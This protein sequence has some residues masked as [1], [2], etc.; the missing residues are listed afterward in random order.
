MRRLRLVAL[1]LLLAIGL[2]LVTLA[3]GGGG[4]GAD[5]ADPTAT[6]APAASPTSAPATPT[7]AASPA[8]TAP[9]G[10]SGGIGTAVAS[11]TSAASPSA[12][13]T[14]TRPRTVMTTPKPI[15]SR[16]PQPTF[17]FSFATPTA[18]EGGDLVTLYDDDFDDGDAG[19]LFVG[20]ADGGATAGVVEGRYV[21]S[22]PAGFWQTFSI[23]ETAQLQNGVFW[24][25]VGV[26]G[27]GAG[28][29]FA[30]YR[31]TDD[32]G[33][34][35]MILC[36]I[37]SEGTVGC[38]S[39]VNN[40][41]TQLLLLDAGTIQLQEL[42]TLV[43]SLADDGLYYEVN[44]VEVGS[45]TLPDIAAGWWGV[46]IETYTDSQASVTFDDMTVWDA[47]P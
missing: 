7:D 1:L 45:A 37:S 46:Y 25:S 20:T 21:A 36:W 30:R 42:N 34:W 12:A 19:T 6:S 24:A 4:D 31:T 28:G 16:A 38:H 26:S 17:G 39:V 13:A 40:E 41:W 29:I 15:A 18:P 27:N 33:S 10:G 47:G 5:D 44:G 32:A 8:A 3:C 43:L 35:A 2:P 23:E 22:A 14:A 9:N 11:P